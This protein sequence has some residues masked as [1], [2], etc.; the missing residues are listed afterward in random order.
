MPGVSESDFDGGRGNVPSVRRDGATEPTIGFEERRIRTEIET[1]Q[2]EEKKQEQL[3]ITAGKERFL[4]F[5][6][7]KVQHHVQLA[8]QAQYKVRQLREQLYKAKDK[9]RAENL[10][11]S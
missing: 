4:W 9:W 6:E 2:A 7:K 11:D 5:G 3:Y 1:W 10:V 8:N